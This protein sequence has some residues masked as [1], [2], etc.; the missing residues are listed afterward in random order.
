MVV[1]VG[2]GFEPGRDGVGRIR[3]ALVRLFEEPSFRENARRLAADFARC[4]AP[5]VGADLI[6]RLIE[7]GRPVLRDDGQRPTIYAR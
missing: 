7:T 2:P 1:K 6:E 3:K 4:D 5:V